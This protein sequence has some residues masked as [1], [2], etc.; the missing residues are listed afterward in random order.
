MWVNNIEI[1]LRNTV[2]DYILDSSVSR[3]G[4]VSGFWVHG[5]ERLVF[6]K[7]GKFLQ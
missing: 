5:N 1:I 3:W 4:Q 7:P 6:V 2:W